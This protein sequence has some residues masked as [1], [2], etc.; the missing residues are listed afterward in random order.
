[1]LDFLRALTLGI[2]SVSVI[3]FLIASAFVTAKNVK[4]A[5]I[6]FG[7]TVGFFTLSYLVGRVALTFLG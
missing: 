5:V 2:V 4:E 1:M 3:G 7:L 6:I